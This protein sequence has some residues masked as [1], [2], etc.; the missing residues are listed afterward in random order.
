MDR[1]GIEFITVLGMPPVEFVALAA[2]LGC[3]HIGLGLAPMVA[4]PHHY[5]L[6]SLRQDAAL[7]RATAAALRDHN[8]SVSLGE[9]FIIRPGVDMR[10]M[11]ADADAMAEL[12]AKTLN[13][14]SIDPDEGRSCDQFA[15]FA[16]M[17]RQ[18]GMQATIEFG[19][20]MAVSTLAGALAVIAKVGQPHFRLLIDTMHLIRSGATAADLAALDPNL[21]GYIQLC[22]APLIS[23]YASYADEARNERLAPGQG[24]LPLREILQAVPKHLVVGLEV[25]MV[26]QAEAGL[27]PRDRLAPCIAAARAC[28]EG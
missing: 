3:H 1:L 26:K 22:D 5:P 23:R 15:I 11:Q 12:G 9:G 19:P 28:I 25:P 8:V 17:A 24:E 18:R 10:D 6:W 4:N 7:C 21:I 13:A 27:S 20:L 14:L 16:E 2:D